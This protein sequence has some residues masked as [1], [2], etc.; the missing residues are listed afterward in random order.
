[1][2]PRESKRDCSRCCW[3]FRSEFCSL[4]GLAH[5][6][7]LV[8]NTLS[9]F[10]CDHPKRVSVTGNKTPSRRILPAFIS[11]DFSQLILS[12]E[13][14]RDPVL[15]WY[16][17]FPGPNA[18]NSN[19]HLAPTYLYLAGLLCPKRPS[20]SR[21]PPGPPKTP[22]M[23]SSNDCQ[24][25]PVTRPQPGPRRATSAWSGTYQKSQT[26]WPHSSQSWDSN[27]VDPGEAC[28]F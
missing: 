3:I 13:V 5:S 26:H 17:S 25:I 18:H 27:L 7:V 9:P 15:S 10:G 20:F 28:T 1:M 19:P 11:L 24:W 23:P 22:G 16:L 4:W 12:W 21:R 8:V 2:A 6:S 14:H